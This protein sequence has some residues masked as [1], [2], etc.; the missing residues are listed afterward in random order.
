MSD[1]ALHE[2]SMMIGELKAEMAEGHRQRDAMFRKLDAIANSV[3]QSLGQQAIVAADVDVLKKKLLEI[4]PTIDAM[5]NLKQRGIGALA[6]VGI[7]AG[8]TSAL[9]IKFGNMLIGVAP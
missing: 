7:G 8:G 5:N 1:G 3:Q 4:Q 9:L 2:V 6:V